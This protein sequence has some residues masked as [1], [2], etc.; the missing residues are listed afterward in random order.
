MTSIHQQSPLEREARF[1]GLL[2]EGSE[3]FC[4][5][6]YVRYST[7]SS[8]RFKT[9][10]PDN[11]VISLELNPAGTYLAYS[12]VDGSLTTWRL[13]DDMS[14]AAKMAVP[15]AHGPEKLVYSISWNP[16]EEAE[17]ATVGNTSSVKIWSAKNKKNPVMRSLVTG[18]KMKNY[19]CRYSTTGKWLAVLTKSEELYLFDAEKD[20]ELHSVH[21]LHRD[22]GSG[23]DTAH[24]MTW[25]N[26]GTHLFVGFKSGRI[27]LLQVSQGGGFQPV[28]E[29]QGH[30]AAVQTLKC[31][32]LGRFLAA[33]GE[34]GMCSL[35]SLSDMCCRVAVNDLDLPIDSV[36]LN[37]DGEILSLCARKGSTSVRFYRTSTGELLQE[38]EVGVS[39]AQLRFIPGRTWFVV[40]TAG[41]I[42][43]R[44]SVER[45]YNPAQ[46]HEKDRERDMEKGKERENDKLKARG[47]ETLGG[48]ETQGARDSMRRRKTEDKGRRERGEPAHRSSDRPLHRDDRSTRYSDRPLRRDDRTGRRADK[49]PR[50]E[51]RGSRFSDRPPRREDRPP[52]R[53]DQGRRR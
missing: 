42:V 20:L 44:Y 1:L 9:N 34:D 36:D 46:L 45:V 2:R 35:W 48:R 53:E 13:H 27:T 3:P 52:R 49:P 6:H 12:R 26:S 21:S 19:Q 17:F 25:D 22:P 31:D 24:S 4:D 43:K 16:N 41:H 23:D 29:W 7:S 8:S 51:E 10:V 15:D 50:R 38:V 11:E 33:G 5:D 39:D 28:F 47:R 14:H 37:H 40:C 32:P 30:T 18:P